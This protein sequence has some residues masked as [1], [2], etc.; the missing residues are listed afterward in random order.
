MSLLCKDTSQSGP[1]IVGML[2]ALVSQS[3]SD[4]PLSYN[5]AIYTTG[6]KGNRYKHN[7]KAMDPPK[8]KKKEQILRES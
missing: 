5:L 8:G 1:Q 4:M 3:T 6:S 2:S 7:V